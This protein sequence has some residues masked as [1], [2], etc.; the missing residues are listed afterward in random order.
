MTQRKHETLVCPVCGSEFEKSKRHKKYCS[1]ECRRSHVK[2]YMADYHRKYYD[3][4]RDELLKQHRDYY[5]KYKP[6]LMK[7][8][9]ARRAV[10]QC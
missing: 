4:H 8:K 7:Q 3:E 2:E 10:T 9:L 1:D 5:R 6:I